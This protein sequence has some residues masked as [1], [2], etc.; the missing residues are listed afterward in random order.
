MKIT[1]FIH[2]YEQIHNHSSNQCEN[3]WPSFQHISDAEAAGQTTA[4][5]PP[6]SPGA[7]PRAPRDP[8]LPWE[9]MGNNPMEQKQGKKAAKVMEL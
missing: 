7:D 2:N 3:M 9:A 1:I 4:G 6:R 5:R 8:R